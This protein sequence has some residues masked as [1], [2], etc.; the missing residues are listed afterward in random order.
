MTHFPINTVST[1]GSVGTGLGGSIRTSGKEPT[2]AG[3]KKKEIQRKSSASRG[4]RDSASRASKTNKN[5]SSVGHR[6][7]YHD[8]EKK[9]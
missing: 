6:V 2:S 8:D 1:A 5:N 4:H 3:I 9:S 7:A